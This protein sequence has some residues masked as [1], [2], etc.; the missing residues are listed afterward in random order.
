MSFINNDDI[1]SIGL[2]PADG[3][4][5]PVLDPAPK[6]F[7]FVLT[8]N[9][10]N[11]S[12]GIQDKMLD[13]DS[14]VEVTEVT[15]EVEVTPFQNDLDIGEFLTQDT[16]S[17][18][19]EKEKKQKQNSVKVNTIISEEKTIEILNNLGVKE[20]IDPITL[21]KIDEAE[22][23]NIPFFIKLREILCMYGI[24]SQVMDLYNVRKSYTGYHE[25]IKGERLDLPSVGFNSIAKSL[26]YSILQLP[27]ND[28]L[29]DE[30]K[31]LIE[32]LQNKFL[33]IVQHKIEINLVANSKNKDKS[34]PKK[35]RL[36]ESNEEFLKMIQSKS[37]SNLLKP[38]FD[39]GLT[40]ISDENSIGEFA[41]FDSTG[42]DFSE[43]E[44][45]T[46][47]F[48]NG[49]NDEDTSA[50]VELNL[51]YTSLYG[52]SNPKE[53]EFEMVTINQEEENKT[54]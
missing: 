7:E 54:E 17:T 47:N 2:V 50:E 24:K 19:K 4:I 53:G 37:S 31:E 26:D 23:I 38:E 11:L 43:L 16:K 10:S 35:E 12:G 51:N 30:A 6:T 25:F 34:E 20:T 52:N 46:K 49:V 48:T 14:Q 32:R 15:E 45:E 44:V 36:L 13:E 3:I 9:D 40:P 5:P 21:S 41:V 42:M 18:K 39:I 33:G 27:I 29:D 1:S 28:E 8:N 22:M